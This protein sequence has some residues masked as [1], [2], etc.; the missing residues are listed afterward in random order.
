MEQAAAPSNRQRRPNDLKQATDRLE[1]RAVNG[2]SRPEIASNRQRHPERHGAS[3]GTVPNNRQRTSISDPEWYPTGSAVSNGMEQAT[4]PV[5]TTSNERRFPIQNGIQPAALPP[6]GLKQA[7]E[8]VRTT[9][10][11]R[12]LPTRKNIQPTAL[13]SNGMEQ[14]TKC[15]VSPKNRPDSADGCRR[16]L[17]FQE[18][19]VPVILLSIRGM[20][21]DTTDAPVPA[22]NSAWDSW[23]N[24]RNSRS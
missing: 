17:V 1:Q 14:A 13:S 15:S 10:N 2:D 19:P 23:V 8:S 20:R 24:R 21:S 6:N 11:E 4:K 22:C 12:R 9:G 7:T 18:S 3:H 16:C 5:R